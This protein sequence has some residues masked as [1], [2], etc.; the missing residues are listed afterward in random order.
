MTF[1]LGLTG[2]IATGK[3]TVSNYFKKVGFP[4]VDA[5]LGARAVVEPGTQGLQAI[6]EHFGEDFLFPNGTLNRK[7]LGDVV[8]TDKDQLKALNQLLLPYIYDWVNDQAQSYQDQGHQLIVLD[9]PLLYET[10][11]QDACD[12]VMLVYVPESIQL[13]RLMDRDNLSEDEAFDRMLSQYNIEQKLRWADIV[14]DNQG[15]IQQTEKQVEAWL[16]I[17]GFQAIK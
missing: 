12:A 7:K 11:Y 9:I 14:I 4:V 15:S 6:K 1:R 8:F 2:S 17:Q 16:S 3:S 10:K 13:Q 5:D